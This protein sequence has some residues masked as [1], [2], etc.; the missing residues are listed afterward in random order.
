TYSLPPPIWFSQP[1]GER[2]NLRRPP[3]SRHRKSSPGRSVQIVFEDNDIIVVDKPEGLLTIATDKEKSRTLY[4]RLFE[5]VK[6][7]HPPE[8]LFIVHR[9]DR[10]ASGLLVFAKSETAKHQLQQQFKEHSAGRTYVA[11]T[12]RRMTRNTCTIETYLAENRIHRCYSTQDRS[13]GKRAITHVK[14]LK[15]SPHR[16][17]AE[18]Q[19][20]TGRK[21]Q[22]RVHLAEQGHPIVGDRAYGSLSNPIRRLALHAAKLT[23]KHPRTG[24]LL[25]FVSSPPALFAS[26][27]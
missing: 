26:L 24:K 19:L 1:A 18:V 22:I 14:V 13:K 5:H 10:E 17:L 7:K 27:T 23:F 21:H 12:E 11:V 8:M 3:A 4:A 6:R 20:E 15:R 2:L 16:T 9:L 25:E